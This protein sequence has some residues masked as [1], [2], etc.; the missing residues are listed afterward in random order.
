MQMVTSARPHTVDDYI[1]DCPVRL[2]PLLNQLRITIKSVVPDAVEKISYGMPYYHYHGRLAYFRLAKNHLG[3]Y[4]PGLD[5]IGDP[6][7]ERYRTGLATLQFPLDKKL[8][9]SMVRRILKSR[10]QNRG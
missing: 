3:F 7:V 1:R 9:L 2:Q 6:E 4:V 10:I 5:L 8:P